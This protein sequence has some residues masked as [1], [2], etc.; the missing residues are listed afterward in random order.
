MKGEE[1]VVTDAAKQSNHPI[2]A[3][4]YLTVPEADIWKRFEVSKDLK[5]RGARSDDG[6]RDTLVNRINKFNSQTLPVIDYYRQKGLLIEIDGTKDRES[7]TQDIMSALTERAK[8]T[9]AS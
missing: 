1:A 2:R 4:I 5:D 7:V 6:G 9:S 3:V 8:N